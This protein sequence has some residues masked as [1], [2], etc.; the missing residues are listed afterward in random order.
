MDTDK[1]Y[2][3]SGYVVPVSGCPLEHQNTVSRQSATTIS[4][5]ETWTECAALCAE[6]PACS[7]WTWHGEWDWEHSLKCLTMAGAGGFSATGDLPVTTGNKACTAQSGVHT[8]FFESDRSQSSF[9][10]RCL[11]TGNFQ[12]RNQ[13]RDWPVC[14][15]GKYHSAWCI[16]FCFETL[17][18]VKPIE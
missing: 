17:E 11:G 5:V 7:L 18:T 6:D 4:Q 1:L 2:L 13:R 3:C 15:P 14:L 12:F 16:L 9:T 8:K 10:M